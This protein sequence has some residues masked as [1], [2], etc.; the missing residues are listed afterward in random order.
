MIV[1]CLTTG[2]YFR[3]L[4]GEDDAT[5]LIIYGRLD[6]STSPPTLL[7]PKTMRLR[8]PVLI[9]LSFMKEVPKP[10]PVKKE[11]KRHVSQS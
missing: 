3:L 5:V 4:G 10:K 9:V 8:L 7:P 2:K 11:R 1:K 6:E